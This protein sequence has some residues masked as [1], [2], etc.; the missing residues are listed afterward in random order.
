MNMYTV[1]QTPFSPEYSLIEIQGLYLWYSG[2]ELIEI[3]FLKKKLVKKVG[4]SGGVAQL[5]ICKKTFFSKNAAP[6]CKSLSGMGVG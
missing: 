1:K 4:E 3:S 5:S 6:S 2:F